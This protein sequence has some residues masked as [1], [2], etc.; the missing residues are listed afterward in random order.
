MLHKLKI[1]YEYFIHIK[2]G[3]KE[4]EVR[5]NDRDYQVGDFIE[6]EV[7]PPDAIEEAKKIKCLITYVHHVLGMQDGYVVLG[8][9]NYC[10]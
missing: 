7:L 6:F 2:E 9:R 4:F 3:K 8:I 1:K 5:I 10:I